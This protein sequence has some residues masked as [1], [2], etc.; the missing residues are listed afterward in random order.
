MYSSNS[1]YVERDAKRRCDNHP[2]A[3]NLNWIANTLDRKA[4]EYS[5]HDPDDQHTHQRS[6]DFWTL[7]TITTQFTR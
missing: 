3:I 2:D 4:N 6:Y 7:H 1:H 5:S